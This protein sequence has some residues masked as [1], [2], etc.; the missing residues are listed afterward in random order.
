MNADNPKTLRT[1]NRSSE[2]TRIP[3]K[4]IRAIPIIADVL[5]ISNPLPGSDDQKCFLSLTIKTLN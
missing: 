4:L 1:T 3:K 2:G 5:D